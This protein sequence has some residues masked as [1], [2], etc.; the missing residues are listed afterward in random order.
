MDAPGDRRR[1][2]A[3]G[4]CADHLAAP[5]GAVG[6]KG[7]LQPQ[8]IRYWLTP[9]DD[10]AF[11]DKVTDLCTLYQEAPERAARGERLMTTDELTGVQ[12]LEPT[13]PD[14]PP[15]PGP[16][17]RQGQRRERAPGLPA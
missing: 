11:A 10:P 16:L 17:A 4:P 2:H 14:L 8:R 9:S 7:D 13:Q 5:C 1:D 3:A 12:A 15:A 6:K